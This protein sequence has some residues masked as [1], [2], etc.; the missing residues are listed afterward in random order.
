MTTPPTVLPLAGRCIGVSYESRSNLFCRDLTDGVQEAAAA[1]GVTVV[2]RDCAQSAQ[3]QLAD[4]A[5]LLDR[6]VDALVISAQDP[7]ALGPALAAAQTRGVPVITVDRAADGPVLSHI[8]SDNRL[9]GQLAAGLLGAALDGQGEVAIVG[10]PSAT[11][12]GERVEGFAAAIAGQSGLRVVAE[13]SGESNRQ[14][15]RAV[16]AELLHMHPHLAGIFA[17]NDVT[18]QGVLLALEDAGRTEDV[19]VVGYDATPQGCAEILRGGPLRGEVAQFPARI[20]QTA[21]DVWSSYVQGMAVP[22]RIEIPVELVTRENVERFTGA[23]RLLRMRRGEVAVAGERVVLFPVR[24]YQLLLNEIHAA[25]PSLLRHIVYHSG[26]ELGQRIAAQV[27]ELYPDPHDRLVVLLED[28]TRGGFGTFELLN[29]D[30]AAGSA[31]VRG[32]D[33]FEAACAPGLAWARTPR[34]VDLYCSGRLA[35]YLTVI[36]GLPTA[37]EEV[38]CQARGDPECRFVLTMEA[39]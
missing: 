38:A 32:H 5:D 3:R 18:V 10:L 31:E 14:R 11:S 26:F 13:V 24:G 9:G 37:C 6:G 20:G 33:L 2:A 36:V 29:L 16:T 4:V 22:E 19:V 17:V 1:R 7:A 21:V 15:T 25:S 34:C 8:T 27:G 30:L 12:V 28:L 35:G 39:G 23:E